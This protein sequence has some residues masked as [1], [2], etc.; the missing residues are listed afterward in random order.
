MASTTGW[1]TSAEPGAVGNDQSLNNSS[2]FNAYPEGFGGS[3]Y[4][5]GQ[6]EGLWTV[7]WSSNESDI[8]HAWSRSL[9]NFE[10]NLYRYNS[11]KFNFISVR[12]VRD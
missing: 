11:V 6:G 2:G 1:N 3:N 8:S 10:N 9:N 7:F 5:A 4:G 12:L